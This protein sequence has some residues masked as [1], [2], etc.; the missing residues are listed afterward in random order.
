MLELGREVPFPVKR[1][2][3]IYD[4][5]ATATRAGHAHRSSQTLLAAVA[6]SFEVYV[7]DGFRTGRYRLDRR[8]GALLIPPSVWLEVDNFEADG[9]CL[10]L[11]SHLYDED[12]YWTDH[13]EFRKAV[14]ALG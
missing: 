1:V 2:Y 10:A 13:G 3:F 8:S 11:S 7:D 4:V 12:D 5:P 9:V 14:Q 6:G